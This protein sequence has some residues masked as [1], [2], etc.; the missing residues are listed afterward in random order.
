MYRVLNQGV[1]ENLSFHLLSR[2][3]RQKLSQS[4]VYIALNSKAL[5]SI[6]QLLSENET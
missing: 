2:Y 6:E 4:N 5:I 1:V 3:I